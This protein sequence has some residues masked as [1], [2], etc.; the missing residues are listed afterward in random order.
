MDGLTRSLAT[1]LPGRTPG[2][3]GMP[4]RVCALLLC[5]SLSGPAGGAVKL[6]TE[7]LPPYAFLDGGKVKG[8]SIDIVRVLFARAGV[9]F[10]VRVVPLKRALAT[11]DQQEDACVFPLERNQERE[12][13]YAWISPL[14]ITR[15]GFYSLADSPLQIRSLKDAQSLAVGIYDGSAIHEYLKTFDFTA[16]EVVREELLNARKL[17]IGRIDLWATDSVSG[18][19]FARRAKLENIH[20]QHVFLTTLRGIACNRNLSPRIVR[21]LRS[22]LK[23]MHVEGRVR[24]IMDRYR[25]QE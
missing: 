5:L 11:V 6:M 25:Y 20:E 9:V 12:A 17:K 7:E 23:Q 18:R 1:R 24:Q 4:W 19:Y 16:L 22:E 3:C 14:L 15:T 8:L 21:S 10:E 2:C 13:R